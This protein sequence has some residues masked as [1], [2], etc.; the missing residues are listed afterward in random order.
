MRISK[1]WLE[2]AEIYKRFAKGYPQADFSNE[3]AIAMYAH[4]THGN[5]LE[6]TDKINGFEL[7][8]KWMDVTL[9]MWREDIPQ[10][11]L[12]VKELLDDGYQEW[13]LKRTGIFF[14]KP[15]AKVTG[16]APHNESNESDEH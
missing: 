2:M 8:K 9:A 12:T 16:D 14:L 4:E 3:A 5:N 7:G 11:L 13:F 15:D 6:R 1:K 10:G